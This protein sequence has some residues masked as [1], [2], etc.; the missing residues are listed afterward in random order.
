MTQPAAAQSFTRDRFTW[1]AYFL[2]AYFAVM[3]AA[4]GP[5]MPFLR[6]ELDLNYTTAALHVSAFA[7]GMIVAGATGERLAHRM[8]RRR[9]FWLGGGGMALGALGLILA[10]TLF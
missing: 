6:A 5:L 8:G 7:L 1:L 2:L 3:Q 4:L 10:R 9:L